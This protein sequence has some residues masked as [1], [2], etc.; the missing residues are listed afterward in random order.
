MSEPHVA[1]ESV[2]ELERQYRFQFEPAQQSYVLLFPEGMVKLTSSAGEI[3][4]RIDGKRTVADIIADLEQS[5]PGVDL[6]QDVI[7]FLEGAYDRG[8]IRI[9]QNQ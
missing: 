9:K 3:L 4:K 7:G 2:V 6:R 1:S 5:F 8:Y